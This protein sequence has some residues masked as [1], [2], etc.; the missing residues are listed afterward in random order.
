MIKIDLS[1]L[2]PHRAPMLLLD[3]AG[4]E[5]EIAYGKKLIRA[6][7]LFLQGHFP[8]DPLVPGVILCEI[9]A[10]SACVLLSNRMDQTLIPF[11]AGLDHV[12]FRKT[13]RPGD[14]LETEVRILKN[15]DPFYWAT[16]K[17]F[18]SGKLC[19]EAEFSFVL[20]KK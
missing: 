11:L 4:V 18:V 19:V 14:L 5:G 9:L 20:K 13:V 7:E 2:L 12:R 6:E 15:K 3:E 8:G 10:Q 17:G 16:G 1:Q